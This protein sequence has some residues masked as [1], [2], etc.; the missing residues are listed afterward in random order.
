[1]KSNDPYH[2][3]KVKI[4]QGEFENTAPYPLEE[5]LEQDKAFQ[6]IVKEKADL[7]ARL[8]AIE[9]R[10]IRYITKMRRVYRAAEN[11][12]RKN[13]KATLEEAYGLENHPKRDQIWERAWD[14]GHSSGYLEVL[15]EYDDIGELIS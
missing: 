14:K 7:V 12:H 5:T 1:M 4:E 13:F 15:N 10:R 9:T 6:K 3:V 8:E 11:A 2:T